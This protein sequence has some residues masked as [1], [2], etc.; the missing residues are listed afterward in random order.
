M[1]RILLV[2][3]AWRRPELTE[4][5]LRQRLRLTAALE[6]HGI[7]CHTVVIAD[8][9]NA[10]IAEDQGHI[11]LRAPNVLGAKFNHGYEV[12]VGG[13]YDW[14]FHVNS[15]QAFDPR[16]I[17]E[18]CKAPVDSFVAAGWLTAVHASG[19]KSITY[20][21]PVRAMQAFPVALLRTCPRP[22]AEDI[23]SGC[24]RS[25]WE[26]LGSVHPKAAVHRIQGGLQTVQ[27]ESEVQLTDWAR[28][29]NIG[30]ISMQREL[31]VPWD[32][33]SQALGP[34]LV[35]D[36]RRFYGERHALRGS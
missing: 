18:I 3:P 29:V 20:R 17:V 4:I 30:A 6:P 1:T 2:T 31:P 7:T 14:A 10:D 22:C 19:K 9:E 26:G 5:M 32:Q 33:F 16:L 25:T 23:M 13:G 15:D 24:D 12:A 34:E 36:M 28:H 8:D 11:V 35:T 21:N 27:F